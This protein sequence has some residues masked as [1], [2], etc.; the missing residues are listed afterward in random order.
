MYFAVCVGGLLVSTVAV[1]YHCLDQL[2]LLQ[3]EEL[4]GQGGLRTATYCLYM[5]SVSLLV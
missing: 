2:S 4:L 3:T 5:I 1:Y